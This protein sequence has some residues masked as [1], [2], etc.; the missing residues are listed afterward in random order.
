[1][2]LVHSKVSR[3][4]RRTCHAPPTSASPRP[5]IH[6]IVT[7]PFGCLGAKAGA[8]LLEPEDIVDS[9]A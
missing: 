2:E 5:S 8:L 6:A 1:M 9:L 3:Q 7:M 4:R